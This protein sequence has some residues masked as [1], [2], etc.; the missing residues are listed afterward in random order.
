MRN[1]RAKIEIDPREA[2]LV[3]DMKLD[4]M[5]YIYGTASEEIVELLANST[6]TSQ[7]IATFVYKAASGS[8]VKRKA[9]ATVE[10]DMDMLLGVVTEGI[11]MGVELAQATGQV[12]QGANI[13]QIKDDALLKTVVLHG[14]QLERTDEQKSQA[15]TD[16]RDYMSDDGAQKGFDYI[17]K[18]AQNEGLNPRDMER[19]GNEAFYGTKHPSKDI[20]SNDIQRGLMAQA[21]ESPPPNPIVAGKQQ[22]EEV[23]A[24]P[25]LM[26]GPEQR[27]PEQVNPMPPGEGIAPGPAFPPPEGPN[28]EIAPP[29]ERMY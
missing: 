2:E 4:V 3:E 14:E 10:M 1:K 19:A 12:M 27:A 13:N 8:A 11:D 7:T 25:P 5:D 29:P 6:D 26:G 23:A 18:R 24:E 9:T 15:M 17:N 21:G 22:P 28:A 20:L 16:L